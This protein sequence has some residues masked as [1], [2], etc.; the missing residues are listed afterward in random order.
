V[1]SD[2]LKKTGAS[3]A[4]ANVMEVFIAQAM[5]AVPSITR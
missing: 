1:Y 2:I 4:L 5:S 3:L